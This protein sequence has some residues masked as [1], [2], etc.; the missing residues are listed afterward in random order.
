MKIC[1]I[2]QIFVFLKL[3]KTGQ[4][5]LTNMLVKSHELIKDEIRSDLMFEWSG[6]ITWSITW[7]HLYALF[8]I[9]LLH[10]CPRFLSFPLRVA[11]PVNIFTHFGGDN[12]VQ[13]HFPECICTLDSN[14]LPE[15]K[16][17]NFVIPVILALKL[18]THMATKDWLS[19]PKHTK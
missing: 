3:K 16:H 7:L 6:P 12:E 5:K 19:T 10:F 8:F 13:I 9:F 1:R 18:T 17:Y 4:N 15:F 14:S 11:I 2:Y